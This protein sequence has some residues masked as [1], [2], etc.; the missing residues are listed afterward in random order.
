MIMTGT[1]EVPIGNSKGKGHCVTC[2]AGT[3]GD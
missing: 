2:H 1:D 3:D